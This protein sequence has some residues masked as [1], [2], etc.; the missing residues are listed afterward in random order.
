M[1]K[2]KRK[3]FDRATG[4]GGSA[5]G[6]F[7]RNVFTE[8]NVQKGVGIGMDFLGA[9]LQAKATKGQGQ[10]AIDYENAKAKAAS[11][12]ARLLEAGQT[13]SGGGGGTPKWVMPVAI[14]GGVLI[15]G[16]ILFFVLRKK[17]TPSA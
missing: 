6:N 17:G 16:A 1:P 15:I 11:E 14:G 8:E 2:D 7:L 10:Q 13:T 5:V 9:K 12:Q 3:K 4:E